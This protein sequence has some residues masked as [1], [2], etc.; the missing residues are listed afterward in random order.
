MHFPNTATVGLLLSES[1]SLLNNL[2]SSKT[3]SKNEEGGGERGNHD[4][5]TFLP[6]SFIRSLLL[7]L[8]LAHKRP[9]AEPQTTQPPNFGTAAG[10]RSATH[11]YS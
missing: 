6:S 10:T 1:C 8:G 7:D 9:G 4:T 2:R 11:D 5:I 3:R